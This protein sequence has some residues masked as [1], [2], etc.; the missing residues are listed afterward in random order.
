MVTGIVKVVI[1][2]FVISAIAAGLYYLDKNGVIFKNLSY[3][4]K[5][6]VYALIFASFCIFSNEY[7]IPYNGALVNVRDAA[8]LCAAF[9]F[10]PE[11][12]ILAGLIGGIE[13]WLCVY[14]GG[15]EFS[16]LA[17]TV[18]TIV[19]GLLGAFVKKY[20]LEGKIPG[21]FYALAAGG[22]VEV[23]HMLM[24]YLARSDQAIQA[25]S[26]IMICAP[27]MIPCVAAAA[28]IPSVII[29][30]AERNID[31]GTI[32]QE[33]GIA[34]NIARGLLLSVLI[35]F[36][37]TIL[38]E[39]RLQSNLAY[40]SADVVL[41]QTMNDVK[42][43]FRDTTSETG[44]NSRT[45]ISK[46]VSHRHI[47]TIGYVV[48]LDKEGNMVAITRGEGK[49]LNIDNFDISK[50][51]EK[52]ELVTE[53]YAGKIENSEVNFY[54]SYVAVDDYY[55]V[56]IYPSSEA[57]LNKSM[58]LLL[59]GLLEVVILGVV[60]LMMYLLVRVV[61][62]K[63][64]NTINK[65]LA[66]ITKGNL[67]TTVDVRSSAEFASLSNDINTTVT[68]LKG[69][70]AEAAAKVDEELRTAKT[71][72]RSALPNV[73]PDDNRFELYANMLAAKDVGGDFYDFYPVGEDKY[74]FLI[75][76]VSGKG[77]PAAMF[78]M[79]AKSV[80][81][82]I[83]ETGATPGVAF[84]KANE[85]LCADNDAEMFVTAWLGI[86]DL[87]TGHVEFANAGHNPPVLKHEDGTFEY[88][89]SRPGFV[90]AGMEGVKY[91]TFELDMTDGMSLFLYTDGVTEATNN[92][93][94]LY[95]EDRLIKALIDSGT[96]NM[97][98]TCKFIKKDVD[99]FVGDAPQFD[100]ITMLGIKRKTEEDRQTGLVMFANEESADKVRAFFDGFV[101]KNEIPMKV[102]TK[103][104]VI[105]DEIYSNI[106][107]YS[108]ASLSKVTATVEDDK[109]IMG[110]H[111]NGISYNPLEKE[112]PDITLSAEDRQ[113][114]GLG[115][116]M[117]KQMAEDVTYERIAGKNILHVVVKL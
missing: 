20:L 101:E 95:G 34:Q 116:F 43:D 93:N 25:H 91:K 76:D 86:M 117:V 80:I 99:E 103:L 112:D 51:K 70:I 98:M 59:T 65:D 89:T 58:S 75:A 49:E 11:A 3:K 30:M 56:G 37:C 7:A 105:V 61:V 111:D 46:I 106:L 82:S 81:K 53:E 50:L 55:I 92:N 12:G 57:E 23:F 115:I 85:K 68:A 71:I 4:Q 28:A 45:L 64:L 22:V 79:N 88:L 97:R 38:F 73:F 54:Y 15:G 21:P 52:G 27:V 100:D 1:I 47:G 40:N 104:M 14:W 67:D 41:T 114:G 44:E 17:C 94:E 42:S 102:A 87:A 83:V 110:F 10:G 13:R 60:F 35:A 72:Q 109:I 84:T 78:M 8:P 16:R 26:I 33:K 32:G 107:N 18:G 31:A 2:A 29:E 39:F 48:A 19:A 36:M 62:V 90:L 5:Q 74:A 113:I 77:I 69:Y 9:Y 63:E 24:L 66:A 6:I 108:G 96:M